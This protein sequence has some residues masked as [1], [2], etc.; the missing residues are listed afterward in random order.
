MN[1]G[2]GLGPTMEWQQR[3]LASQQPGLITRPLSAISMT[4]KRE[5]KPPRPPTTEEQIN[6]LKKKEVRFTAREK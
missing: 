2:T 5:Q 1:A 3:F 4:K 6:D